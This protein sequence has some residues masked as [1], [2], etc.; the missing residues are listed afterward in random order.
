MV[1]TSGSTGRSRNANC[2]CIVALL[3]RGRLGESAQK[4]VCDGTRLEQIDD[5]A[6]S[7]GGVIA[8]RRLQL[9]V[10]AATPVRPSSWNERA[11]PVG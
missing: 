9:G 8:C 6:K 4:S 7:F 3:F 2:N 11:A 1:N 5:R 10:L